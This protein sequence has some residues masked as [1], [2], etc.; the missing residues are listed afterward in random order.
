MKTMLS[1]NEIAI[2]PAK[3]SR[4]DS[5]R[6]VD[7]YDTNGKLPIFV[8]PMTCILNDENFDVFNNSLAIP[9]QPVDFFS[10]KY[11]MLLMDGSWKALTLSQFKYWFIE[12][13]ARKGENYNVLIDCANGHMKQLYEMVV[14][15]KSNYG[16]QL[17]IMIGNIAN[18]ETY[19]VCC[20]AGVDY[21]RVGIGGGSGCTTSVLTGCHASLPYL[22][23]NMNN[24]KKQR[25]AE[26]KFVTKIIAD[27]GVNTIG[28]IVKSLAMGADYVMCGKLFA[29][30]EEAGE[31]CNDKIHKQYYGQAS[32]LGQLDRFGK[33]TSPI[34]GTFTEIVS[35]YT[36]DNFLFQVESAIRSAMSYC[37][38]K[39]LG[40]FIGNVEI[41][42]QSINE[43]VQYEK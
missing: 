41:C 7:P 35:K 15:A 10:E 18:P 31:L 22:L 11:G 20:H 3:T 37:D 2:I 40:E 38:T 17:C 29:Y 6:D 5:R 32:H 16:K 8:A 27:G 12:E 33:V 26:N 30:C 4:I 39:T 24:K 28:K 9:I 25:L 42:K 23:Y 19:D 21:V 13:N 14:A 36:L 34:E 43:F 1:L